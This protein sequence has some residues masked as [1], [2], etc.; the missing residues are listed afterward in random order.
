[1]WRRFWEFWANHLKSRLQLKHVPVHGTHSAMVRK[2][3][4]TSKTPSLNRI[5]RLPLTAGGYTKDQYSLREPHWV[6]EGGCKQVLC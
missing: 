6:K 1:M 2:S 3:I 5:V 4:T